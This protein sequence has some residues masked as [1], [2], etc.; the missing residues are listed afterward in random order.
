MYPLEEL[1]DYPWTT[2]AETEGSEL[3][4][5]HGLSTFFGGRSLFWSAWCP[6]P[7]LEALR[8]FPEH[9]LNAAKDPEFWDRARDVLQVISLADMADPAFQALQQ[10]LTECLA[11]PIEGVPSLVTS[12]S[13]SLAVRRKGFYGKEASAKFSAAESL[14]TLLGKQKLLSE[15]GKGAELHIGLNCDVENLQI[16]DQG[17]ATVLQTSRRRLTLPDDGKTKVVLC[18]GVSGLDFDVNWR[19]FH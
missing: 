19:R 1:I 11:L 8:D 6:Q 13:S 18:A 16:D 14:L 9:L 3:G 17:R 2:S 4:F 5:C 12:K 7:P 15:N 10:Q